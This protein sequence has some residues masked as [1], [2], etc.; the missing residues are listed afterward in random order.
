MG[1]L[2]ATFSLS[3]HSRSFA[4][5]FLQGNYDLKGS[6]SI[7]SDEEPGLTKKNILKAGGLEVK[8]FV[9]L[10]DSI[11]ADGNSVTAAPTVKNGIV[12]ATTISPPPGRTGSVNAINA[13]TGTVIWSTELNNSFGSPASPV[14]YN[15]SLYVVSWEGTLYRLDLNGNILGS[16]KP[17]VTTFDGA[18]SSPIG[19]TREDGRKIIVFTINP[20]DDGNLPSGLFGKSAVIAVDANTLVELWRNVITQG[21]EGGSGIAIVAPTYSK[22]N[23]LIYV[24]TG[25]T[26]NP[27]AVLPTTNDSVYAIRLSNGSTQWHTQTVVP[28]VDVWNFRSVFN[29]TKPG[30]MD[31]LNSPSVFKFKGKEYVAAGS[32]RGIFYVMDASTGVIVNGTGDDG[33]FKR[34]LDAFSFSSTY[35]VDVVGPATIGGYNVDSG[36]F[37][38]KGKII[39]FGTLIDAKDAMSVVASQTPPFIN[40]ICYINRPFNPVAQICPPEDKSHLILINSLGSQEIGRYTKEHSYLFGAMHLNKMIFATAAD[41]TLSTPSSLE[42]ID[43]SDPS[44]PTS[45]TNVPLVKNGIEAKSGGALLAISNCQIFLGSGFYGAYP[46]SQKVGLYAIGLKGNHPC[47]MRDKDD[48]DYDEDDY[49]DD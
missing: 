15:N 1:V 38:K 46:A 5:D 14:I 43:V 20:N 33:Y 28:G 7:P 44:N 19:I 30:D 8:W 35:G 34:G 11:R 36:Y 26:T 23:G 49:E 18:F 42:V 41:V 29:P 12:Y 48:K 24:G 9:A 32:K 39:H 22:K 13:A 4:G 17:S 3:I 40:G 37:K 45:L 16:Y 10:P 31:V 25:Q 47:S 27:N 2:L 6:R 21:N